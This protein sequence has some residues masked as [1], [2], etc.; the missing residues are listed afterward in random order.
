[1]NDPN[2]MDEGYIKPCCL[3]TG[4][5]FFNRVLVSHEDYPDALLASRLY[6]TCH[7]LVRSIVPTHGIH[8]HSNGILGLV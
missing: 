6:C 4:Q 1:M 7:N 5:L 2:G 8:S 3:L